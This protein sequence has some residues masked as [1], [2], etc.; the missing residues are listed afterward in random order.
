[1]LRKGKKLCVS[2]TKCFELLS[3][4]VL[5]FT[6]GLD[7]RLHPGVVL[8]P[9]A[10]SFFF[11]STFA[12]NSGLLLLHPL[13]RAFLFLKDP[14]HV[15]TFK[16]YPGLLLLHPPPHSFLFL[17]HLSDAL[18]FKSYPVLLLLHLSDALAFESYPDLLLLHPLPHSFLFLLSLLPGRLL[19]VILCAF[20][21]DELCR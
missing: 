18:A 8:C 13:F 2:E 1:L 12:R 3:H 17:L 7:L 10:N 4:Q 5:A 16:G 20:V 11:F 6:V 19:R 14:L 21:R 9:L 15:F